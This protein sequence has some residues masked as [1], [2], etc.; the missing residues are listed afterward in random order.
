MTRREDPHFTRAQVVEHA[1]EAINIVTEL[2]PPTDLR[3]AVFAAVY[4]SLAAKSITMVQ[5][6]PIA[7]QLMQGVR[8]M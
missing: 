2:D 5:P 8:G 7:A 1:T 4:G 3:A 6:A